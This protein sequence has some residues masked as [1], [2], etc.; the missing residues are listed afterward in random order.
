[1]FGFFRKNHKKNYNV[2]KAGFVV[3]DKDTGHIL[4]VAI[5]DRMFH[6]RVI[7][8]D[9][10]MTLPL[11][12]WPITDNPF[13]D[14]NFF[15]GNGRLYDADWSFSIKPS[16]PFSKIISEVLSLNYFT[17]TTAAEIKENSLWIKNLIKWA[18]DLELEELR[19]EVQPRNIDGGFWVGF[20]RDPRKVIQLQGLNIQNLGL[21]NLPQDLGNLKNLKKLWAS[22]NE[23][24]A[25]PKEICYLT[26]L[27]DVRFSDNIITKIPD[28]IGNLKNL[29]ILDLEGNKINYIPESIREL[30]KLERLDLRRQP[31]DLGSVNTP[32]TDN[33]VRA[34]VS[35]GDAVRW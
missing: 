8:P 6:G 28:E 13:Q 27:E 31:I 12:S 33:Q 16:S 26:L 35:L 5:N 21:S 4:E 11:A 9:K 32:L 10:N 14:E 17:E 18:D 3:K 2:S 24:K 25:I 29:M 19:W 15:H 34:I 23:L 7:I 20:P 22:E 30:K 1:M